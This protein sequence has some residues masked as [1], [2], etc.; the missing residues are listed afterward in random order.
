MSLASRRPV[1]V[2]LGE[3][4]DRSVG[5]GGEAGGKIVSVQGARTSGG[6]WTTQRPRTTSLHYAPGLDRCCAI[7]APSFTGNAARYSAVL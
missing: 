3:S 6:S 2:M 1:P 4:I 7:I 5:E